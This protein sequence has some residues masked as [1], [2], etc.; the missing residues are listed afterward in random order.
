MRQVNAQPFDQGFRG[1]LR[2]FRLRE[3][4]AIRKDSQFRA[5]DAISHLDR[6]RIRNGVVLVA[7]QDQRRTFDPRQCR[8]RVRPA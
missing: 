8:P 1:R 7:A 2:L 6:E 3:M 4:A 5:V